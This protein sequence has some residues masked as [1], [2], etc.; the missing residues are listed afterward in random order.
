MTELRLSREE[1]KALRYLQL[2]AKQWPPRLW[3]FAADGKLYVMLKD[4]D[5]SHVLT[6][7]GGM[8]QSMI[9]DVVNIETDGG[10]W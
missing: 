3:L 1:K 10:D 9:I 4:Y 5:G 7:W 2:A 6:H 8:D